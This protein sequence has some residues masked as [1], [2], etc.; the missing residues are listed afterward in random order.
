MIAL[1]LQL[2][3][4][5]W[6]STITDCF[7]LIEF[8]N[9]KPRPMLQSLTPTG[10]LYVMIIMHKYKSA[11]MLFHFQP[12]ATVSHRLLGITTTSLMQPGGANHETHKRKRKK[13]KNLIVNNPQ[14]L[15]II[16]V[17]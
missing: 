11:I 2:T 9:A 5:N 4:S 15:G 12:D 16:C 13:K 6:L 14:S 10:A 3:W 8:M 7:L 17:Q 1:S